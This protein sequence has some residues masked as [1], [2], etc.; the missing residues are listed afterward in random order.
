VYT[1][2]I[3]LVALLAK[4]IDI[5][6]PH[7]FNYFGLW[8]GLCHLLNGVAFMVLLDRLGVRSLV[9]TLLGSF[10]AILAPVLLYRWYHAALNAHFLILLSLAL[11]VDSCASARTRRALVLHVTLVLCALLIHPYI[12]AMTFAV[13]AASLIQAGRLGSLSWVSALVWLLGS[14]AAVL[15]IALLMGVVEMG[16]GST[17]AS[18]FGTY[19]TNLLSPLISSQSGFGWYGWE[20]VERAVLAQ[21]GW[22]FFAETGPDATGGQYEG[23]AYLGAGVLFLT[24][25]ALSFLRGGILRRVRRH[26]PLALV[27][28][29]LLLFALS[30]R[31][32]AG[33][34]LVMVADLPEWTRALTSTFRSSGRFS[35]VFVYLLLAF[36]VV[37]A[38]RQ[39]G[40]RTG[41]TLLAIALALQWFDT[42]PLRSVIWFS[43]SIPEYAG[44]DLSRWQTDLDSAERLFVIPSIR[45]G[46]PDT[47]NPKLE[48]QLLAAR[49]G[50]IPTNSAGVARS[51]KDCSAETERLLER[52]LESETLYALFEDYKRHPRLLEFVAAQG[53]D[54]AQFRR[55]VVCRRSQ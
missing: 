34:H 13:L 33:S 48:L 42:A 24:V 22:A 28:A 40:A 45:C 29:M 18:G 17:G 26:W 14:F 11:Y 8:I 43:S 27:A 20:L 52:G 46:D 1:D 53:S 19:S 5:V 44:L 25:V 7:G 9:P 41:A 50:P 15:L 35:W 6:F 39:F 51:S 38:V 31:I 4:T 37:Q 3:P 54:C 49:K 21:S 16:G 47:K 12:M 55:G 2:S 30:N 10:L 36:V 32:F 23:V